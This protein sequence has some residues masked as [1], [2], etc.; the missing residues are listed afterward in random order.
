MSPNSK[1]NRMQV[2]WRNLTMAWLLVIFLLAPVPTDAEIAVVA[3]FKYFGAPGTSSDGA[4]ALAVDSSNNI[5]VTG[6]V[7]TNYATIKYSSWGVP[8]W[9]NYYHGP[10]TGLD[11]AYAVVVDGSDNVI[12]TGIS[13]GGGGTT[14]HDYATIKYSS[15]GVPLWTNRFDY[16]NASG[17]HLDPLPALA[18]DTSNDVILTGNSV[19]GSPPAE[20]Y[21]YVTVKYS[22]AG[23]PLW[24]NFYD[25][26]GYTVDKAA[27]M[28]VDG[29]NNVIVTGYSW[30]GGT[31]YD[32]VTIKYSS[33]GTPLWTNSY[34]GP[35]HGTDQACAVATDRDGGVVVTGQSAGVGGSVDYATIK[36]S[37]AG[38]PLWTN[39]YNGPSNRSDSVCAVVTDRK[40][41]VIVTGYSDGGVS[42]NDYATLKYSSDGV[43]LWTNRYSRLRSY[44]DDRAL[45]VAVDHNDNPIV[46]GMTANGFTTIKY[47][48]AGVPLWTNDW[49]AYRPHGLV[50]DGNDNVIVTG[51]SSSGFPDFITVKYASPSPP[52]V[53][54]LPLTNGVF[55]LRVGEL[56]L[57]CDVVIEA[58]TSLGAWAPIF[59]NTTGVNVLFYTDPNA[60]NYR[61]RFYRAFQ[62]PYW[63]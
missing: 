40:G 13:I 45:A 18:V 54:A 15:E 17:L 53:T 25:G 22:S 31:N 42:G 60:A 7:G 6:V 47:S 58:S 48:S 4:N 52:V 38:V 56:L 16:Y 59:T 32:F 28:T 1:E 21:D 51:W 2:T 62:Y 30:V 41:D 43:P 44:S 26:T 55:Q 63:L 49:S 10:A 11:A 3:W 34:D 46:K 27:A 61:G 23:L 35:T 12:V 39:W 9:T 8:I 19:T 57:D 29:S 33:A 24:T 36:Y 20:D 5:V 50:V 37:S 14:D